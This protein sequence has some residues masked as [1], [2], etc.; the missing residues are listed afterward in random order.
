M[1]VYSN[2]LWNS[3]H[4]DDIHHIVENPFVR[5][6]QNTPRFFSHPEMFSG[7]E[8][9]RMYR[10]LLMVTH[11]LNY[12]LGG[13]NVFGYHLLNNLLHAANAIL[14]FLILFT[15]QGNSQAGRST[16]H[17]HESTGKDVYWTSL[18]GGLFFGLHT[19]NT[20]SVNYISS[21][22]VLLVTFFFLLTFIYYIKAID[23]KSR[24]LST[25]YYLAAL[26]L[27][28]LAL[29]SKE[30]AITLPAILIVYEYLFNRERSGR[31]LRGLTGRVLRYHIPFW[32][33]SL[34][35]LYLR[36]LLLNSATIN[37]TVKKF[38][39]NEGETR[40][41]FINIL[42]QVKALVFYIKSFI[43]PTGLS[44][45]HDMVE[46]SGLADPKVLLSLAIIFCVLALAILIRNRYGSISFAII[47]FFVTI[48]PETILPLHLIVNEHRAYLPG[49]GVALLIG[50]MTNSLAWIKTLKPYKGIPAGY[51]HNH[52]NL[53]WSW[54]IRQE[55][56][57]EE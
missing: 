21:R 22:S 11:T 28:F 44:I 37:L 26:L 43:L 39:Y 7:L 48:L 50:F 32:A 5:D 18:I 38:V 53:L 25:I 9:V 17:T 45:E 13:L 2:S 40:S 20:Q 19:F 35:Y 23:G 52:P 3:F 30:I 51:R 12:A 14:I 46:A 57:M 55:S 56:S 36:K 16:S 31:G 54:H 41:V 24:S 6:I 15:L 1:A 27:Y 10:P 47:W 29:L 34:L 8:G 33:I 49:V 42:T 4:F